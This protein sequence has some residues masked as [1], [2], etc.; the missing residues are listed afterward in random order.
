MFGESQFYFTQCACVHV[1]VWTH[2]CM[3]TCE[4]LKMTLGVFPDY[5][6][7]YLLREDLEIEPELDWL[8]WLASLTQA[9]ILFSLSE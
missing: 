1:F 5:Y 9:G 4:G 8:V 6:L 2:M 7:I 3:P